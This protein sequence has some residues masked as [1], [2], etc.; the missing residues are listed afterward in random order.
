[1]P[2]SPENLPLH[3][4]N[5]AKKFPF[6]VPFPLPEEMLVDES[7]KE[8]DAEAAHAKYLEYNK[9]KKDIL[10]MDP[11][12]EL[13]GAVVLAAGWRPPEFEGDAFAHLGPRTA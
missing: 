4:K 8:L 9:G 10:Q 7:G 12:G 2:A 11:D 13:Y 6:D 5:R 1:L 3:L